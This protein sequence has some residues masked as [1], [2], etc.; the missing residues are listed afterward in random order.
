[1]DLQNEDNVSCTALPFR[2]RSPC[3]TTRNLEHTA[4]DVGITQQER[5][6]QWS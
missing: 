2:Q 3:N 6:S 5:R 1:V 4:S